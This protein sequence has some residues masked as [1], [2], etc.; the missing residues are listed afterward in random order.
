IPPSRGHDVEQDQADSLLQVAGAFRHER[1][2]FSLTVLV[3]RA[4]QFDG[5]DQS[6]AVLRGV[7]T[8]LETVR[9]YGRECPLSRWGCPYSGRGCH[10]AVALRR[11][12]PDQLNGGNVNL[13]ARAEMD[14]FDGVVVV[15]QP[16][17]DQSI[18]Q[19]CRHGRVQRLAAEDK[20]ERG[21]AM[22]L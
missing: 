4:D 20:I 11:C 13:D 12:R 19:A 8:D 22:V 6:P 16:L 9:E 1:I 18:R 5:A 21:P 10:A 15:W 14:V 2:A 17:L 7:D 3:A